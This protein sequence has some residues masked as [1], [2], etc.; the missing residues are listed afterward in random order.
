ADAVLRMDDR[1]A[2]VEFRKILDQRLDVADLFLLL[3]P[4]G[5]WAGREELG[6]GDE[7]DALFDPGKSRVQRRRG[8]AQLFLA[9]LEFGE[10][11]ESRRRQ[12]AGVQEIEQT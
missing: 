7:V 11:V 3:A 12:V 2:D 5:G 6:F 4:A 8:D 9:R 1:V 10:R